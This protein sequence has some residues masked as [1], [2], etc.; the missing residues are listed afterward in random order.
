MKK[1]LRTWE[2]CMVIQ[3]SQRMHPRMARFSSVYICLVN[4]LLFVQTD[5]PGGM[6]IAQ[7]IS[8]SRDSFIRSNNKHLQLKIAIGKYKSI[9]YYPQKE[10]K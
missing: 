4:I 10:L 7:I 5:R 1:S 2:I 9:G 8:S 3:T 6:Q